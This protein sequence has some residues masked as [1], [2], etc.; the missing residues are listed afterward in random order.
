VAEA[1]SE[2]AVR[3][4]LRAELPAAI[5]EYRRAIDLTLN[6]SRRAFYHSLIGDLLFCSLDEPDL[7]DQ[8]YQIAVSLVDPRPP[9]SDCS[10][11]LI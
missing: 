7:A 11:G 10:G 2:L 6:D 1:H 8:E 4:V 9:R 5:E 3:H